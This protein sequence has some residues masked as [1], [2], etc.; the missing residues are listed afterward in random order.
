MANPANLDAA[1][2]D[3][4]SEL[5]GDIPRMVER[6]L[7]QMHDE[8]PEFFVR[9]DDPDFVQV[10]R[11][12]Y[13]DQL[14]FI[15]DGLAK[16]RDL[17]G[18]EPPALAIEEA[19]LSASLGISL[20]ALLQGYRIGH[21]LIQEAAM[22]FAW[23]LVPDSDLRADLL[24]VTSRWLFVYFD[25][26]SPRMTDVYERERDLLVRDRERRKR[27]LVRDVL[28]GQPVDVGQLRYEL[29][30]DHLGIVA[31]GHMPER[32]LFVL[33]DEIDLPVLSVAGTDTTAWG[34]LG[35]AELGDKELRQVRALT[36][37][38]GVRVAIGE[39]GYGREGFRLT[40]RQAWNAYRIARDSEAAVTWHT[41]VALLAL[42][43]QDATMARDFVSREL[44]VLA[45]PD[46]RN[47]LLR[48]TLSTYFSLGHNAVATAAALGIHDRTV[49]YRLRTIEDRIGH[50]ILTRREE[51]GVALRLAAELTQ[52]PDEAG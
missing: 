34:W 20:G 30:R 22:R 40:H 36:P 28:D 46:E 48:E 39:P 16:G 19:R 26:L 51:L 11:Q 49:L 9:D 13:H 42:T 3:L 15:Y 17:E 5:Q 37:P 47:E 31:W 2:K 45:G 14:R 8:A 12:S 1:L 38:D 21:R 27:Q 33:R 7:A 23:E 25:W 50:P 18:I 6:G 41:E 35:A 43:L 29:E 52:G 10:Y 24:Q 44:G 32:A 4:A